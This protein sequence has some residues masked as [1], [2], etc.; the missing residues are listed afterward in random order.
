MLRPP[1]ATKLSGPEGKKAEEKQ[2]NLLRGLAAE[3]A[4]RVHPLLLHIEHD[5]QDNS[6]DDDLQCRVS[7]A[8]VENR[9]GG[10]HTRITAI[11]Q[12]VSLIFFLMSSHLSFFEE[13]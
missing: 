6:D 11:I 2:Y 9:K 4:T 1:L 12:M 5:D 10:K 8:H 7:S 13:R 3:I